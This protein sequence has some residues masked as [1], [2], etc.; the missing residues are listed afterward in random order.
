MYSSH[1]EPCS[2]NCVSLARSVSYCH[3]LSS[4]DTLQT[5]SLPARLISTST[6]TV[7][8]EALAKLLSLVPSPLN[9]CYARG[10]DSL[11]FPHDQG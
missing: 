10:Y 7:S 3:C 4:V 11:E 1:P 6:V 5:E 2:L 8:P 9:L